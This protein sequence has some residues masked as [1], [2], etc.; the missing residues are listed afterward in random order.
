MKR[1]EFI[2][3]L[4]GAAAWPAVARGQERPRRI[5]VLP[6]QPETDPVS[7]ARNAAF[8]QGLQELGWVSGR[9]VE[10]EYRWGASDGD[11]HRRNVEDLVA[12]APDVILA[13]GGANMAPLLQVTHTIPIIFVQVTD[14]VG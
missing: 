10:I 4:G 9:N 7:Q 14:P 1:R 12:L 3:L 6:G 5:G 11:H 8:L 2:G 13:T